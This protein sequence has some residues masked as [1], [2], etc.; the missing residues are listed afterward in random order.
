MFTQHGPSLM[1]L[2]TT[3]L[4]R[5]LLAP[6]G[7]GLR[8][9]I[10]GAV[11]FSRSTREHFLLTGRLLAYLGVSLL[12]R[13]AGQQTPSHCRRSASLTSGRD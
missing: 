7:H 9:A 2:V 1:D 5:G 11:L 4:L 6:F 3:E 12:G 13:E 8:T 10:L